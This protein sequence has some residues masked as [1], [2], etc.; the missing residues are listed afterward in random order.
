MLSLHADATS[1]DGSKLVKE[2][3]I[4]HSTLEEVFLRLAA[5][6]KGVN[7]TD[8]D[9]SVAEPQQAV[10]KPRLCELC[11]TRPPELV[12]LFTAEVR[13]RS[14]TCRGE[15]NRTSHLHSFT[16]ALVWGD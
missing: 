6:N 16:T 13:L 4:S 14:T 7:Y 1:R 12:T 10:V 11:G 8:T 15:H 2:W 9:F 3:G 5:Q